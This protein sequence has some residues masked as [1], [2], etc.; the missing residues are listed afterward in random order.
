MFAGL[1]DAANDAVALHSASSD[2]LRPPPLVAETIALGDRKR[3]IVTD[4]LGASSSPVGARLDFD[5][6]QNLAGLS[7]KRVEGVDSFWRDEM[8]M[9]ALR[10]LDIGRDRF[11]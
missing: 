4:Q 11:G 6:F 3:V 2:P 7:Q 1:I 5:A 9:Q 10:L 8:K